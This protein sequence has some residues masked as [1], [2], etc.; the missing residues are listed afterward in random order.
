MVYFVCVLF[1]LKGYPGLPGGPGDIGMQGA[2]VSVVTRIIY[3]GMLLFACLHVYLL[4][5]IITFSL[6]PLICL[7][8]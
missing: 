6:Y 2:P 5:R 1:W 8:F 3:I 4:K 7:I